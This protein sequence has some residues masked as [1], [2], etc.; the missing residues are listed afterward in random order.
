M[1]SKIIDSLKKDS[2]NK[3]K[4]NIEKFKMYSKAASKGDANAQFKLAEMYQDGQG[5]KK[6]DKMSSK[7]Y[8][9]AAAQGISGAQNNLGVNYKCGYGVS[10]NYEMACKYFKQAA[11]QGNSLAQFNLGIMYQDGL[12]VVKDEKKASEYYTLAA[13]Q[14]NSGAQTCIGLMYAAGLGVAQNYEIACEYL[15]QSAKQGSSLGQFHLGDMYKNGLGVVKDEKK[16]F[17]YFALAAAQ[18]HIDA[19]NSLGKMYED[20]LGVEKN[21][22]KAC[23]YYRETA[24][25]GNSY[26]QCYLGMMYRYGFGVRKDIKKAYEYFTQALA[27][28]NMLAQHNLGCLYLTGDGVTKDEKKAS[29]FFMQASMQGC[30]HSQCLLGIMYKE[31]Q[32]IV[33]DERKAFEYHAKAAA[34]GFADSQ[35]ILARM[36]HEGLA[37]TKDLKKAYECYQ[38][39]A[40]QGNIRAQ[41]NLAAMY[42]WGIGVEKNEKSALEWYQKAASQGG[43]EAQYKLGYFYQNGFYVE[44]NEESALEWYQ[45]AASQGNQK[46]QAAVVELESRK[47]APT[48][49]TE[50]ADLLAKANNGDVVAQFNLS[51]KYWKGE[52]IS[53]DEKISYEWCEKAANQGYPQAKNALLKFNEIARMKEPRLSSQYTPFDSN[54]MSKQGEVKVKF[55]IVSS[56]GR[57]GNDIL[58]TE[59]SNINEVLRTENKNKKEDLQIS[60]SFKIDYNTL[61]LG[62]NLGQGGFGV[63]FQGTWRHNDVA[64]KQLLIDDLSSDASKEFE[65]EVQVMGKLHCP[66]I[67]SFYGY[68]LSPKYCIVMEYMPK[69]SLFSVL[70]S[71][72]PLEWNLRIKIATDI[73]CGLAFLHQEKILH[74]DVKS[75]NVLLDENL[76]AKLTDFGLSKIKNESHTCTS[77]KNAVGSLAWMAPELFNR[78]AVYTQ[79]SDIYSLGIT[80]WELVSRKI[81]FSDANDPALIPSWVENGEREEIPVNCPKKLSTLIQA[82]WE[83]DADKRPDAEAVV[84]FLKSDCD[85]FR[86]F[87][88]G[89]ITSKNVSSISG[90]NQ[91]ILGNLNSKV[92]QG[93]INP[94]NERSNKAKTDNIESPFSGSILGNLNSA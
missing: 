52:G 9:Q 44:K 90:F 64:I 58:K 15:K 7:Y 59:Q 16:A 38:Q 67:I 5:V 30:A 33:K 63:V 29:E 50:I 21:Y 76:K 66:N 53:K 4:E 35:F 65:T 68:S 3:N 11:D 2:D 42:E 18:G 48:M 71:G 26:G 13:A 81:P 55:E 61:T 8:A 84:T 87:L 85:E 10:K 82:C 80:L 57:N 36:Y 49:N 79:K 19:K 86:S 17:E 25:Q 56:S 41:Y 27:Q 78:K 24:K 47:N 93:K 70:R 23:E 54:L 6:D 89:F 62:K 28:G 46:A 51:I 40:V 92:I 45:K 83:G 1:F 73:A 37:V 74:R 60:T 77:T 91:D 14:G 32:G 34:Q 22:E 75:L 69:G 94:L 43:M 12:G 20:G 88:P 39:A 72:H 31:G